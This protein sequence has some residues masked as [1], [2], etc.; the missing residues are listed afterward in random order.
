MKDEF[1]REG[2]ICFDAGKL[3]DAGELDRIE[4]IVEK[5]PLEHVIL[6]DAD[7]PNDVYVGR[8]MTDLPGARPALVNE[9]LS[10]ELISI[11]GD[12]RR[13]RFFDDMIGPGRHIRRAQVNIMKTKSFIGLHVDKDSNPEYEVAIVL[14]L[15]K[16]YGGGEFVT[17]NLSSGENTMK[18]AY[19]SLTVTRCNIPHE[20][21]TVTEGERVSLVYFLASNDRENPRVL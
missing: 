19:R 5:V 18:T 16:D 14:Q 21:K 20:V 17:H 10:S 4:R 8:F 7:E 1:I 2:T 11:L 9:A 3:F 12:D 15:G 6:G 13:K